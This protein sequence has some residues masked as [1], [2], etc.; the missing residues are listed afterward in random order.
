MREAWGIAMASTLL[1]LLVSVTAD[2]MLVWRMRA[3]QNRAD[4]DC[5]ARERARLAW[6]ARDQA[7]RAR[8]ILGE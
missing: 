5:A 3:R 1:L 8:V 6:A 2:R 4:K 7:T